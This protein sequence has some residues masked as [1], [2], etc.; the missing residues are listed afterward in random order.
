MN[1]KCNIVRDLLPSYIDNVCSKDSIYFIEEH[2]NSCKKCREAFEFME[3]DI[4]LSDELDEVYTAEVKRPFQRVSSFFSNQ[5]KLTNYLLLTT[6]IAL[7]IGCFFLVHSIIE[8]SEYKEEVNQ[9]KVVEQE[10][11]AI[12]SDVFNVLEDS[13]E[14]T[15]QEEKQLLT[16]FKKYNKKLN[17]LAVFPKADVI[18]WLNDNS[19]VK[20]KPTTIYPINYNKAAII[21]GNEGIIENNELINPSDYDLGTVV[22]ANENWVIQYEYKSSYEQTIEKHHQ[23]TY[24]APTTWNIFQTPILFFTLFIVLL[25]FWLF[26]M[27]QNK[28]FKDVMG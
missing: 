25:I 1:N 8:L 7:M 26:L 6:L 15:E 27:R 11:E 22:M 24:Y 12:M 28:R 9:F 13:K 10:K 4:G 14:L 3:N 17:L 21:V 16:I 5:K 23:L 19:S 18:D 20:N 2:M